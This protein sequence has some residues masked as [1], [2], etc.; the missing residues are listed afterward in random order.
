MWPGH[1]RNALIGH[2][3]FV[4]SN[5][6]RGAHFSHLYNSSNFRQMRGGQF[7]TVV[8]AGVSAA[9]WKANLDPVSD[10]KQISALI[11]ELAT[12]KARRFILISTVDVYPDTSLPLD[13]VADI[14]GQLHAYGAHRLGLEEFVARTFER[15]AIVRL[16]ALF[17]PGLK[18]NA[19]FDLINDHE[20]DRIN[21]NGIFQW[22]P[23]GRLVDDLAIVDRHG[24]A[25]VNLVTEPI[26]L[27]AIWERYFL[28]H[29]IPKIAA[30]GA[31]YRLRS[32]YADLFGG[33]GFYCMDADEVMAELGSFVGEGTGL[34]AD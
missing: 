3:G 14:G 28:R 7:D 17:G 21:P 18:K 2:T 20:V 29:P 30:P 1:E 5:L 4:G 23:V 10:W 26:A 13:E 19:L 32:K 8:C 15:S 16:P 31:Q 25:R 11:A 12:I 22:Y 24:L 6:A 9:K 27:R 34:R 33:R